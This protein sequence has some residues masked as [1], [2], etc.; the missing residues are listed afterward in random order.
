MIRRAA[1]GLCLIAP[2]LG[3]HSLSCGGDE[4]APTDFGGGQACGEDEGS[5]QSCYFNEC[6]EGPFCDERYLIRESYCSSVAPT[7][8]QSAPGTVVC[9]GEN[10]GACGT[11]G[12]VRCDDVATIITCT[13]DETGQ[14]FLSRGACAVGARCQGSELGSGSGSCVPAF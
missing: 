14:L 7:C 1:A 9:L 4:C 2:L 6:I 11:A 8:R 3:L 5:I 10:I 13:P 12:F